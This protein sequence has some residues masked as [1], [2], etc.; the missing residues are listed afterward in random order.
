MKIRL[1]HFSTLE[2]GYNYRMSNIAAAIG[3]GQLKVLDQRVAARRANHDF[4]F[5]LLQFVLQPLVND[6]IWEHDP[7]HC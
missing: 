4:Y 5:K 1:R 3:V 2:T 6:K 7:E